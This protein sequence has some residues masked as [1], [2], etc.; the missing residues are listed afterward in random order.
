MNGRVI[1][2]AAASCKLERGNVT[3]LIVPVGGEGGERT[4]GAAGGLTILMT[5]PRTS[6]PVFASVCK[7]KYVSPEVTNR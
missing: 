3:V 2:L 7:F 5:W 4:A 1:P 6:P